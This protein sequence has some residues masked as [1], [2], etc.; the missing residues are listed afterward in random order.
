MTF[1]V[2]VESVALWL[3]EPLRKLEERRAQLLERG[4]RELHLP[5]HPAGSGDAEPL[6]RLDRVLEQSGLADARLAMHHQDAAVSATRCLEQP[7]EHRTL[8][9][10]SYQ[11]LSLDPNL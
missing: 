9:L 7:V 10:P 6:A 11:V 5:F 3:R 1:G 4:E 8:A 2:D